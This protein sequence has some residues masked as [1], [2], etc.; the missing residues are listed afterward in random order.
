M[1]IWIIALGFMTGTAFADD[2]CSEQDIKNH[3]YKE[4]KAF[5]QNWASCGITSMGNSDKTSCCLKDHYPALQK[6]CIDCFGEFTKCTGNNCWWLCAFGL[7]MESAEKKC[8]ACALKSCGEAIA[9]CTGVP[10]E[11]LPSKY[12]DDTQEK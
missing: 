1:L 8:A 9:T 2:A 10:L 11:N 5:A 12:V 6:Q 7:V 3:L 4:N